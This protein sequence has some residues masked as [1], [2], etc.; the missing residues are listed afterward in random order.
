[1]PL[2][3]RTHVSCF[4]CPERLIYEDIYRFA[5]RI[6]QLFRLHLAIESRNSTALRALGNTLPHP[7]RN[8]IGPAM[9]TDCGTEDFGLGRRRLFNSI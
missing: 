9:D 3:K 1:M 2:I 5:S 8:P 6:V 4:T 7:V